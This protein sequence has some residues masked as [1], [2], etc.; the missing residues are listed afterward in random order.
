MK[1]QFEATHAVSGEEDEAL[2]LAFADDRNTPEHSLILQRSLEADEQDR[3]LGQDTYYVELGGGYGGGY[4]GVLAVTLTSARLTLHLHASGNGEADEDIDA[5]DI[6]LQ[7]CG[8]STGALEDA[9][10]GIFEG[11]ATRLHLPSQRS[12]APAPSGSAPGV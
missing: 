10:L 9:L 3:E 1:Y 5:I 7:H 11:T 12:N 2:Q 8:L 4:G 6:G